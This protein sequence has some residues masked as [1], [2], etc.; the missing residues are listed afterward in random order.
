M[1]PRTFLLFFLCVLPLSAPARA[2]EMTLSG[3]GDLAGVTTKADWLAETHGDKYYTENWMTMLTSDRGHVLYV[4]FLRT[5]IGVFQ[6]GAGV[7]VSLTLPGQQAKHL[8]FEYKP[9]DFSSDPKTM[10]ITIGPNA[11]RKE[12]KKIFLTVKEQG[13]ELDLEITAWTRG[14]KFHDG[15]AFW[16]TGHKK[17]LQ[18]F[19]HAPRGTVTGTMVL[20]GTKVPFKGD[21]YIDHL[22]QNI[23]GTEY[24]SRWFVNRLFHKD[25]TLILISFLTP[26]KDGAK[27]Q[28][29]FILTDRKTVRVHSPSVTLT[30]SQLTKDPE[31]HN[32]HR[33]YALSY[34]GD[35][36]EVTGV[37]AG[38]TIHDRDAMLE[39]M[40][41]A[42]AGVV[43][44]VAGDPITYRMRGKT[45]ATITIDG[46]A[47]LVIEGTSWLE[48]V[49]MKDE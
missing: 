43:K 12:G 30:P 48:S 49:V 25:L 11:L 40:S 42:Q 4:N 17:W 29:R 22:R 15:K 46:Q 1:N 31:G 7:S 19:V 44:M 13:F 3:K 36:I 47:P 45:K 5:N 33:Q 10:T 32:Y 2:K 16:G 18:I 20:G 8:A 34:K 21:A 27:M 41:A 38:K 14:V 37:A 28:H 39:R 9:K 26:K 35:G 23:L 24:A 6:G